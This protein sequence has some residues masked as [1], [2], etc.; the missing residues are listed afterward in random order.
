M[1]NR[2]AE[3]K[4][5]YDS[6]KHNVENT[7][8]T[9][10]SGVSKSLFIHQTSKRRI[11]KIDSSRNETAGCVDVLLHFLQ[12]NEMNF[13]SASTNSQINHKVAATAA[14]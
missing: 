6:I 1:N 10:A 4:I 2:F 8:C 5:V 7:V 3:N 14:A 12:N 13:H 11:K 9:S